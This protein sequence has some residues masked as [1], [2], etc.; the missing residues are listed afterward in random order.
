LSTY[1]T[2]GGA[3]PYSGPAARGDRVKM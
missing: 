1:P 3:K 2:A